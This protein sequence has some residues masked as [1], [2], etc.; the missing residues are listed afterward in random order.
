MK[1]FYRKGKGLAFVLLATVLTTSLYGVSIKAENIQAEP[2]AKAETET[3]TEIKSSPSGSEILESYYRE[4]KDDLI[5]P[6]YTGGDIQVDAASV[7]T[8]EAA[9]VKEGY[10]L[11]SP[12][13]LLKQG[14]TV[15]FQINLEQSA[16]YTIR[17]SYYDASEST[18]PVSC[19]VSLDG[20][21]PYYEMRKQQFESNWRY[22]T[23]DFSTDR[24]GNEIV[25]ESVRI[26]EWLEK[27][28]QDASA[29]TMEPF[30]FDLKEG[31]H[32]ISFYSSQGNMV[33]ESITFS[34]QPQ[35]RRM[36]TG[37][38]QGNNIKVIE[39]EH[40]T[41][42]NSAAIR[43]A[44]AYDASI[45]PYS[46]SNLKMNML[47]G[48]S[49]SD[50]GQ[51]V[52][53]DFTVEESGY[54]YLGFKYR[55]GVKTDFPVFRYVYV[56]GQLCTEDFMNVAF[57]YSKGFT[58]MT[59]EDSKGEPVGIYLEE[60][61]PHSLTLRVSLENMAD[62]IDGISALMKEIND[63]SLQIMKITGNSTSKYRDFDI[64][65]YIPDIE[66]NLNNWADR[67]DEL[68][69]MLANYN[70]SAKAIGEYSTLKICVKQLR[71]LAKDVDELPK[72]ID[73]L[74]QGDSSVS[75]YL[76]NA[77]ES[78]YSAPLTLDQIYIYQDKDDLPRQ[79]GFFY[80]LAM[81][82]CRFFYSFVAD[83]Y[84]AES[85]DDTETLEIWVNRSRLYLELMQKMA[86]DDFYNS[87][88]I[89]VNLSLM[90]NEEKL[91]LATA[92]GN[93]PDVALGVTYTIPAELALR[94]A[95][96][97][98]SQFDDWEEVSARFSPGLVNVGAVDGGYYLL[99][100]TT[101]FLVLFYRKDIL[102][103]L[104]LEVPD[105]M[106]DVK[107]MLPT[108]KRYG[109][110]FYSHI[111]GHTGTKTLS[112]LV[113]FIYQQSGRIYGSTADELLVTSDATVAAFSEMSDLFTIY[114]IPYEVSSFYQHF[115][116]G[117]LP[118][119]I[120]GFNTYMTLIN[121]APEIE[122]SWSLAPYPGYKDENGQ[123]LRNISGAQSTAVI[124]E[125]SEKQDAAWEF[126]KW[127]TS[128]D[129]QSRFA[130]TLQL[131]YGNE[132]MWNTA[133]LE[134][135]KNLPWNEGHKEAILA[136]LDW[137]T[138][139][140]RVPGT[141]MTQRSLSN[142]LNDIV[143]KGNNVRQELSEAEKDIQA[144]VNSK[145][146]EFGYSGS[147]SPGNKFKIKN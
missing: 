123:V 12:A 20:T 130:D 55:Q 60:G 99:P 77:H 19:A 139:V 31:E 104:G 51:S 28:L 75:Q 13:V 68:Y 11:K 6:L 109:M 122:N 16:G 32:E 73:E 46:Y 27:Y 127:W 82:V 7:V 33:I 131:T 107:E 125:S 114:D 117:T 64:K 94:G 121:S 74:Y 63:V 126:L 137:V 47:S 118:I 8:D 61:V 103:G 133:N 87:T 22:E 102:D 93:A 29:V 69:G 116:S 41:K 52:T 40:I 54:Y 78:L 110:D 43:P 91:V 86:D 113:P 92:S 129:V 124:F 135:F 142:A 44:G 98:L 23:E 76:A 144:E 105:T 100:E 62:V 71:S 10:D 120:S 136:M 79:K 18:L 45:Y 38:P 56:D 96:C 36:K 9:I 85:S 115:R 143:L 65:A 48:S 88:G 67:I 90:P 83:D 70:P 25:P 21:F 49:F 53:Y 30:I 132:Y 2:E 24:Y 1:G 42:K 112:V 95:V 140:P 14:E 17:I 58:T 108:L 141:Y 59:V 81:S 50:G 97:D 26:N 145:L 35:Y 15:S 134:A 84:A 5:L 3:M 138:E 57:D 111:A 4:G 146:E 37:T 39:A 147:E 89:K 106:E 119:G 80:K 34:G 128:A 101:D 66:D 72:R